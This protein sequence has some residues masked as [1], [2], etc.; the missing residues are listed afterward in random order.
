MGLVALALSAAA[1]G[2]APGALAASAVD[3]PGARGAQS[4]P[5]PPE[6]PATERERAEDA[7]LAE[8]KSTGK[9]VPVPA[10]TTETDTVVANPNGT[11]GLTRSVGPRRTKRDGAWVDLDAT[12][13]KVPDG[14]LRPKATSS[15][16]ILSGGGTAPLAILDQDGKRLALSWPEPLPAPALDGDSAV[17]REVAPGTDLKVTANEAGGISQV[18]VVKSAEAA[19][20]PKL[21]KLTMGVKGEGVTVS[22]DAGGSLKAA[23]ASG[24]TVF[25]APTPTMWDSTAEVRAPLAKSPDTTKFSQA[26]MALQAAPA[27][28][29]G[30]A[31]GAVSDSGGPG[32]FAKTAR[33]QADLGKDTIALTPNRAFLS[34]PGT[35]YPVYIDPAWVPTSRGTQHWAWV[36]SASAF[37]DTA[38]YDDYGNKYDPGVGVQRW[39]SPTGLERYYAQVSTEDLGDKIIK[40]ASFFATQSYAADHGCSNTHDVV[41]HATDTLGSGT[42]W[43]NQPGDWGVLGTSSLNSAGGAGCSG[44]TTRGEWDVR[45]HLADQQWRG[46]LTFGLFSAEESQSGS[47]GFKRF[48]RDR[49]NLPFLYIEYNRPPAPPWSLAMSPE[50]KNA[51]G[52]GCGW[53]GATAYA[54][55]SISAWIGDPDSG[56]T[57]DARFVVKD[58]AGGA[59]AYDSG[60][61][62]AATGN[63]LATAYPNNLSDGHS[64]YWLVIAGDG[65]TSSNWVTGCTFTMDTQPP[66]VPVVTSAEYPPSGTLPGSAKYIGQAGTFTVK[67]ADTLSG[68]LYYEWAFN[69][70]IPVGGANR[71]DAA[72]D[73]S[74]SIPLT[75]TTWGTNVLRVQSVDRAGNR[76]QPQTYTFYVPDNPNAKTTLGDITG[77]E[78]VD[79]I[80]PSDNGDLIVYPTAT[81]PAAGGILASD[82]A[83]SPGGK[84]WG[85]GTLTT[86][87]GGNGIRIDDLWTYREGELTL[88][89]NSLTQGGLAANG[90]LYYSTA[91]ALAVNRPSAATCTVATTG[92]PCGTEYASNWSR[93]KQI[94]AVGDALPEAG[95]APR[96]DLLTVENNGT[97][98]SQLVLFQ[99]AGSVGSL[100]DPVAL[101]LS[102]SGWD[103]LTLIA[104]GDVTGDGLPDLWARDNATGDLY[105]YA[106]EAG[107]PAALGDHTKR[108]KIGSGVT[109]ASFPVIGSS[110]DTSA[111]GIPDLWALDG[112]HRLR[113]WNG[114]A[115]SG[116]VT[117]F[118]TPTTMGD[119][120]IS[121]SHWKLNEGTGTTAADLRGRLAATVSPTGATWAD[122]TV[123][124]TPTKVIDF[125]GTA[126]TVTAAGPGVDTTRS[127][128][129]SAWVRSD[130]PAPFL[131]QDG[132]HTSGFSLWHHDDGTWRFGMAKKDDD[133]WTYDQTSTMNAAATVQT[134]VWTQLTASYDDTTGLMALYVNGTL[135]G[136]GHHPKANVW[137]AT[138]PL[139]LGRYK[140][141]S[142]PAAY[143]DGRISN[144]TLYNHSTVPSATTT[145]LVTAASEAKCV[146]D[147]NASNANGT[148]IQLWT[149]YEGI[150]AQ[151][152]E[153]RENGELRVV[154][155]CVDATSG[156][157][158]NGTPIQLYDCNSSGS[159]QWLPTATSGFY[160]PQSG[161]CIDLPDT[162]TENGNRLQLW[163]CYNINAQHWNA[164]GLA[165]PLGTTS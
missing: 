10:S 83:N 162:R 2:A 67:S 118:R 19:K 147:D 119:A 27:A 43:N 82:K 69:S 26:A 25:Q 47:I 121:T 92:Q 77:D 33:V 151:Q 139:V 56:Q 142:Q 165:S 94:L 20:D 111:D 22:A 36:Q 16:L 5:T 103:N 86:H 164:P 97:G 85:D 152:F 66:S 68:V 21:A 59:L 72:A 74:A 115:T 159:Q 46:S 54:G 112:Q 18:L 62:N 87:R 126:G 150:P 109:A 137:N 31:E 28:T 37:R 127:F 81:D 161:R 163:D 136:T 100:R 23:D 9:P 133:T 114:I 70:A 141:A 84:G 138:G 24:R 71:I 91:K 61:G 15:K 40:S 98:L 123:A 6:R 42:T 88:Y 80:A 78:R 58:T 7:A 95:I 52:N 135:A 153:I 75:P 63:H 110:G 41:L 145:K 101:V 128:T 122:D 96:N 130:K 60:W 99:G 131:S 160:N 3:A 65:D 140:N 148:R 108:T 17:Y 79:F 34:D 4:A 12:L 93:V 116:K 50:P 13:V 90:G 48:T 8:A 49:N 120:R 117:G 14:T 158:A 53:V 102:A 146:D 105:Q 38:H 157:T 125:D 39:N 44:S 57:V 149:C 11:F 129:V 134:G 143:F 89:R 76:S 113:T 144:V 30:E 29:G 55:M 51:N 104:P 106:N 64:Y 154:G 124:G 107:N 156:G 35:A 73:G 45:Q 32:G 132:L 155:K 1:I